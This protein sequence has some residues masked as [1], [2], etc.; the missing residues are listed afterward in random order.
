VFVAGFHLCLWLRE[1][2]VQIEAV[3][4]TGRVQEK[5]TD[6]FEGNPD[7]WWVHFYDDESRRKVNFEEEEEGEDYK[8]EP[9]AE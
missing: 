7:S 2:Q 3:W 4:Y 8:F 5:V 9:E 6:A 1:V